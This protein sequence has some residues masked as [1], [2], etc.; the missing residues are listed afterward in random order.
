MMSIQSYLDKIKSAIY[1]RD[2]RQ[3]I[4]DAIKTTYDDASKDGN[5]N[6]EVS[7]ARGNYATLNDRLQAQDNTDGFLEGEVKNL[8]NKKA[9]Q[10]F[11]DAQFA[12]IVSGAPKGTYTTLSEL[13]NAY[14]NGTDGVFLVLETGGGGEGGHWYYWNSDIKKWTDGGV[15]QAQGIGEGEV[16]EINLDTQL[17]NKID[18]ITPLSY[19][20]YRYLSDILNETKMI[21]SDGVLKIVNIRNNS[22]TK[23]DEVSIGNVFSK[24]ILPAEY[25]IDNT[26][27]SLYEKHN[28]KDYN[29]ST[30]NMATIGISHARAQLAIS[31]QYNKDVNTYNVISESEKFVSEK[32]VNFATN[33]S[34][35]IGFHASGYLELGVLKVDVEAAGYSWDAAGIRAYLNGLTNFVFYI[36]KISYTTSKIDPLFVKAGIITISKNSNTDVTLNL[37]TND[38]TNSFEKYSFIKYLAT[39]ENT[40]GIEYTNKQIRLYASFDIGE[41]KNERC[42]IVQDEDGNIIPHQWEDDRFVNYQYDKNMG[43]YSDGSLKDGYI[44]I[45]DT[46]SANVTKKYTI[47][48]YKNE[49]STIAS[50][51]THKETFEKVVLSAPN[52]ELTFN[53]SSKFLLD[54][55]KSGNYTIS[56]LQDPAYKTS[57]SVTSYF[58][59]DSNVKV[60]NYSIEGVG[61]VFKDMVLTLVYDGFFEVT[62]KTRL[63]ANGIIRIEQIFRSLRVILGNEFYGIHNRFNITVG[64][65]QFTVVRNKVYKGSYSNGSL[66][67]SI[68]ILY[69]QGD[70]PRTSDYQNLPNYPVF[71]AILENHPT[72]GIYKFVTGWEYKE[73]STLYNIP[74]NE[75]FVSGMEINLTGFSDTLSNETDRAFN[76]LVGRLTNE[77][78]IKIKSDILK[79][80]SENVYNVNTNYEEIKKGSQMGYYYPAFMGRIALWKMYNMYSLD[81]ISTDYKTWINTL[82]GGGDVEIM[83]TKYKNRT[84][85]LQHTSRA[86]PVAEYLLKEYT[87]LGNQNEVTYYTNLLKA[88][89]EVLCRAVEET[90]FTGLYY[91]DGYNSN[92]T[93]AGLRGLSVGIKLDP[94]NTRWIDAYNTNKAKFNDFIAFKNYITDGPNQNISIN[95]YIHYVVYTYFDYLIANENMKEDP[96]LNLVSYPFVASNAYGAVKEQEYCISSSRRGAGHTIAYITYLLVKKDTP[97]TLEQA[98][99]MLERLIEQN[100]PEGGHEHPLES[101]PP[102]PEQQY[103][104]VVP[105]ELQ[106]LTELMYFLLDQNVRTNF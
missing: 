13:V 11:V 85:P 16:S 94:S 33:N 53:N 22:E 76:E 106:V 92:G 89:A 19:S 102:N 32:Q 88:Y 34:N 35:Y 4:Y 48:V 60:K 20:V 91:N 82:F 36:R 47:Y 98:K 18:E 72:A 45:I 97:S 39:V 95:Q 78:R 73:N 81:D 49:V 56:T 64:E 87:A 70:M 93:A 17:K 68:H 69:A 42:I 51:I 104:G 21:N 14:P 105:F 6:M 100:K 8:E 12:S 77:T 2:V 59:N 62:L 57:L 54:S 101:W 84:F 80:I 55:V 46:I 90:G 67:N 28:L 23:I 9:D 15:Y 25:I 40:I 75:V 41:C 99:R 26:M 43:R 7:M 10:A 103:E 58:R 31:G 37:F 83:W 52:I 71:G 24:N 86:F 38:I 50:S 96:D 3:A 1:G 5:A 44:W 30:A 79:L 65:A 29:F 27:Y 63:F 66:Q 74:Q 61:T